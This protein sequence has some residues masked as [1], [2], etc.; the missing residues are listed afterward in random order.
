MHTV[1]SAEGSAQLIHRVHGSRCQAILIDRTCI[2][3][4]GI[5]IFVIDI[6]AAAVLIQ[7]NGIFVCI[8]CTDFIG[9]ELIGLITY[10][11]LP[12]QCVVGI[13]CHFAACDHDCYS[14]ADTCS[15]ANCSGSRCVDHAAVFIR[16][17]IDV[18]CFD[19]IIGADHGRHVAEADTYQC[20][21]AD[22]GRTADRCRRND[23]HQV[24]GILC[25]YA[26]VALCTDFNI[27]AG[28]CS[29]TELCDDDIQRA[30]DTCSSAAGRTG[31]VC[32][33]QLRGRGQHFNIAADLI[34]IGADVCIIKNFCCCITLEIGNNRHGCHAGC[35]AEC[36]TGCY[37]NQSIV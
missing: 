7:C 20:A 28:L 37:I 21:H 24:I 8:G 5:R 18:G 34:G 29:R 9:I 15:T 6:I 36:H 26:D 22:T 16:F 1:V 31:C 19:C 3:S 32:S 12:E 23:G 2:G 25:C 14:G 13:L 30:A 27:I 33:D 17:Y 35:S 11:M 10:C 4:Y